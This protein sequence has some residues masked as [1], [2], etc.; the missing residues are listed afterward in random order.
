MAEQNQDRPQQNADAPVRDSM[1]GMLR[2]VL[3]PAHAASLLRRAGHTLREEGAEQLW[4]DVR[5]RVLLAAHRD[6]WR[7]R[8]DIPTRRALRM[9]R[10]ANRTAAQQRPA[11]RPSHIPCG[12]MPKPSPSPAPSGMPMTQ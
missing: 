11:M 7:H 1:A 5:F 9:K 6:D 2:R 8:A 10:P 4:R 12:P 3:A